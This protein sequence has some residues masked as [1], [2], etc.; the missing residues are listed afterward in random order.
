MSVA[1]TSTY[2]GQFFSGDADPAL[3]HLVLILAAVIGGIA[4][5]GGIIWEAAR[6]GHLRTWPTAIVFVGVILEAAATVLLFEFDESISRRQTAEL[7]EAKHALA[8]RRIKTK[9]WVG[10]IET[11]SKYRGMPARM[12]MYTEGS[13]DTS[14][15]AFQIAV[16]LMD[17]QWS[18]PLWD[19]HSA[20]SIPGIVVMYR[21]GFPNAKEAASALASGFRDAQ[22]GLVSGPNEYPEDTPALS[23]AAPATVAWQMSRIIAPQEAIRILIGARENPFH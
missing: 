18:A 13:S 3:P 19:M 14:P 23:P 20:V 21:K 11:L 8:D 10:L 7:I 16:M 1:A 22:I 17:A 2:I 4:V 6:A 9:D 12:F 5:G 15:L